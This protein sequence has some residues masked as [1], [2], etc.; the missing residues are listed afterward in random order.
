[1]GAPRTLALFHSEDRD[2]FFYLWPSLFNLISSPF[3]SLL[4]P[5]ILVSSISLACWWSHFQDVSDVCVT[6]AFTVGGG[7]WG[8][9]G[10]GRMCEERG[11]K[12]GCV[13]RT[14]PGE[15]LWT[16][17]WHHAS[18][19]SWMMKDQTT[20]KFCCFSSGFFFGAPDSFLCY[21]DIFKLNR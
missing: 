5:L 21:I 12:E 9:R 18:C 4:L 7:G 6:H 8:E 16:A 14:H 11:G 20:E 2:T 17:W 1:M 3:L 13:R 19:V 15:W 10:G